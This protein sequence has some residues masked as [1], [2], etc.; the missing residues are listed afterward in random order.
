M[1][2][3]RSQVVRPVRNST[4]AGEMSDNDVQ[5]CE[6]NNITVQSKNIAK[7][8]PV[9]KF[10]THKIL[11]TPFLFDLRHTCTDRF[12]IAVVRPPGQGANSSQYCRPCSFCN[13]K[14]RC[15]TI[16]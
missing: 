12:G 7:K 13:R 9:Y 14:Q 16:L 2:T 15:S 11:M 6:A 8:I 3:K 4:S 10:A 5:N 1:T